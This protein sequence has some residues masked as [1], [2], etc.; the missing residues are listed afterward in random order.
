MLQSCHG[1]CRWNLK[2]NRVRSRGSSY[3][4]RL[5]RLAVFY[6][7]SLVAS[8]PI[9]KRYGVDHRSA[10]H[11]SAHA[12]TMILD[13]AASKRTFNMKNYDAIIIGS[14]QGGTPLSYN[15]AD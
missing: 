3:Q 13:A 2:P 7:G 10:F 14:G 12:T 1:V 5:T 9:A 11:P 8:G 15:L 6:V 4:S